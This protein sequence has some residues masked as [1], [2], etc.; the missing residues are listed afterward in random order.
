MLRMFKP[1]LAMQEEFGNFAQYSCQF[2]DGSRSRSGDALSPSGRRTPP[3]PTASTR[4]SN[5]PGSKLDGSTIISALMQATGMVS[6][7]QVSYPRQAELG[8]SSWR[9]P[10]A[11]KRA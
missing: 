1:F 10:K 5:R 3:S 11:S 9:A 7:H 8:G 6:D 2:V 4:I